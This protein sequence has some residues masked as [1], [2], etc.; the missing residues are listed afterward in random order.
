MVMAGTGLVTAMAS[1]G[2]AGAQAVAVQ[3]AVSGP[4]DSVGTPVGL[5]AVGLGV[6]GMLTGVL[7]RKKVPVQP[8]NQRKMP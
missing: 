2:T 8:E 5:S 1:V 6:L 3:A 4:L 7:R